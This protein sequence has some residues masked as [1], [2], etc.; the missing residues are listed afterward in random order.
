MM[1]VFTPISIFVNY[2][3]NREKHRVLNGIQVLK[4]VSSCFKRYNMNCAP[5]TFKSKINTRIRYHHKRKMQLPFY[6][7]NH[8]QYFHSHPPKTSWKYHVNRFEQKDYT[9]KYLA[10][11]NIK[12]TEFSKQWTWNYKSCYREWENIQR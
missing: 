2:F 12:Y 3:W 7:E 1:F 6:C 10:P 4:M 9:S 11:E 8:L 5:V